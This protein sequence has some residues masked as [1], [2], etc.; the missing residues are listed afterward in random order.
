[1]RAFSYAFFGRGT[2]P[3]HMDNVACS[4]SEEDLIDCSFT[5]PFYDSHYEDAGVRCGPRELH[6]YSDGDVHA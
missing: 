2:G 1:M 3:I 4:G 5:S 6:T